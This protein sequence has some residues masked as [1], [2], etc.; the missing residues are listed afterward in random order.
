MPTPNRI[1][2]TSLLPL[3]L[4]RVLTTQGRA[5]MRRVLTQATLGVLGATALLVP[6]RSEAIMIDV[7]SAGFQFRNLTGGSALANAQNGPF[8]YTSLLNI[9]NAAADYWE[10]LLVGDQS[11]RIE[12]GF[13][14]TLTRNAL[15]HAAVGGFAIGLNTHFDWFVDPTPFDNSEFGSLDLAFADLGGGTLNTGINYFDATGDAA[16]GYDAFTV[17]LHEIGHVLSGPGAGFAMSVPSFL[18]DDPLPFA[19]SV[20]PLTGSNHFSGPG[21]ISLH[22][23]LMSGFGTG[24]GDRTLPSDLDMPYVAEL[25]GFT[26]VNLNDFSPPTPVPEPA[27][28][29]LFFAGLAML[30]LV[31]T[32]RPRSHGC[33]N[34]TRPQ[35]IFLNPMNLGR[36]CGE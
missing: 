35:L 4:L 33:G 36:R 14:R 3:S 6:L 24:I 32:R 5:S 12:L 28:L 34:Q 2:K 21:H 10:P 9:G 27:T 23:P 13:D 29:A 11:F 30:L 26:G 15:A 25:G 18:I 8:S 17:L 7:V 16:T 22:D 20:V 1:L 31:R 19:G